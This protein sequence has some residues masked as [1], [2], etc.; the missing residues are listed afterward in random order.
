MRTFGLRLQLTAAAAIAIAALSAPEGAQAQTINFSGQACTG[1]QTYISSPFE[2]QGFRFTNNQYPALST[3]FGVTC[4]GGEFDAGATGL[5]DEYDGSTVTMT[6]IAG[7]PFS[8]NSISLAPL[9]RNAGEAQNIVFTGMLNA[10]G[11]VTQTFTVPGSSGADTFAD[12]TFSSAFTDLNSLEF[13][14]PGV[15]YYQFTNV[16]IAAPVTTTPEPSSIALLGTGL[17]GLVPMV[18]RRRV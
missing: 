12:Y 14:A 7:T 6:S 2:V 17:L 15:P 4:S 10:G 5:F 13:S 3:A 8:I 18:R 1:L 11:T 16:A 9:Y